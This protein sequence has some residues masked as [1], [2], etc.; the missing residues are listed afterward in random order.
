MRKVVSL[1][2]V[3][4]FVFGITLIARPAAAMPPCE[5]EFC[6]FSPNTWCLESDHGFRLRCSDFT[7]FYCFGQSA[8]TEKSVSS[9]PVKVSEAAKAPD[10]ASL[11][12][13]LLGVQG[14]DGRFA[15]GLPPVLKPGC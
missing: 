2:A 11:P 12:L 8:S 7:S 1:G 4:L 15:P 13:E 3:L 9:A 10:P 14:L 5:C 6:S